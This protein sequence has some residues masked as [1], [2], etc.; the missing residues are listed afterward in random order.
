MSAAAC[1]HMREVPL[2]AVLACDGSED[3]KR[4]KSGYGSVRQMSSLP[5]QASHTFSFDDT[6]SSIASAAMQE[7]R[8]V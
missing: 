5:A 3:W 6:G 2:N 1:E 8:G 7:A 4:R